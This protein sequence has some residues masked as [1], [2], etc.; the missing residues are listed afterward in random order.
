MIWFFE[1]PGERMQCEIR[2]ASAGI[3]YEL[4]WTSNDGRIHVELSD[5]PAELLRRRRVLE[6]W[7]KLDGWICPGRMAPARPFHDDR[8][9]KTDVRLH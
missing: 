9:R 6:H 3:G 2:Q 1:R 7:L 5:D 8:T 4:V